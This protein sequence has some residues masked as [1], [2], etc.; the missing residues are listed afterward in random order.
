MMDTYSPVVLLSVDTLRADRFTEACF[1]ESMPIL[2]DDFAQFTNAY[3][4]GN[5]TPFA[6]P[7]IIAGHPVVGDGRFPD[8]VPTIA[9]LFDEP[10]TGFSNNGH[11]TAERG[12]DHGFDAFHD[13][14][15]PDWS[16][17]GI[18]RVKQITRLRESE[19]VVKSYRAVKKLAAGRNGTDEDSNALE[20]PTWSADRVTDFVLR[21]L[22]ADDAFV[23]GHY[24]DP[25]KPFIPSMAVDGPKIDRTDEEIAWLNDYEHEK[26]PID[27]DDMAFLEAL[28]DANIRYFDRELARL[29]QELRTKRWYDETLIVLVADHGEL[30]GE[31][32]CMFHPMDIDPPDELIETP[33]L[34][35]YPDG[36]YAG[37]SFEHLVQHAD[38]IPTIAETIGANPEGL[39][40]N[41]H[42]LAATAERHVISKSNTSIRLT[43]ADGTAIRRRDG[44]DENI[45][46]LSA[47]GCEI[48]EDA[49]FPAVR[50]Q[51]NDVKGVADAQR[52][53]QL[54]ALGYR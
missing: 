33:L 34:V 39:P 23:W 3:S 4:H 14:H 12:Y 24:M 37:T 41:A 18:D 7:G 13:Q 54:E 32:G 45:D 16:P 21:R 40:E 50:T 46:N 36:E 5:A 9:D 17:S 1:P 42:P 43:E 51:S 38:I 35:K 22:V 15:A 28:Y 52:K 11:L 44:T 31:H 53:R 26:D 29:L 2:K 30:F 19:L 49:T 10:T 27:P 6:F 20:K 48:L 25:H 47:L 8:T